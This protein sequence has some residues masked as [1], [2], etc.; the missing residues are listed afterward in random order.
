M[1]ARLE[2]YVV[3]SGESTP[4]P[5][6][7]PIVLGGAHDGRASQSGSPCWWR[8][9]AGCSCGR[10]PP[11][12]VALGRPSAGHARPRAGDRAD[13]VARRAPGGLCGRVD[14]CV[15][16]P[17]APAGGRRRARRGRPRVSGPSGSRSGRRTARGSCSTARAGIEIVSALGGPARLVVPD[18]R[19]PRL[20]PWVSGGSLM[21]AGWSPDGRPSRSCAGTPAGPRPGRRAPR[22]L[23]QDG[24]MHSFA[25]SPD[26]RWIACVRG[27]RQ[28]RQPS[29]MFGNIGPAR[30]WLVPVDGG[31]Q[32]MPVTDD[33]W[34]NASP[35]WA[36]RRPDAA[37]PTN[38]AGGAELLAAQA[39]RRTVARGDPVR[40]TNGLR[41]QAVSLSA[42]GHWLACADWTETS[43][44][45]S[46]PIPT[47]AAGIDPSGRAGDLR[48]PGHRVDRS[49][50][51]RRSAGVR[52]GSGGTRTCIGCRSREASPSG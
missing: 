19:D 1:A 39:R 46:L 42:N 32:A 3:S 35:T 22:P 33:Q 40:L 38:R 44:V 6:P 17:G 12:G 37:L 26:G 20:D 27:N 49:V 34:F 45:W 16:D 41:A 48:Q 14:E 43:N 4:A 24:E 2:S 25:W 23:T 52:L 51:G 30:I 15:G 50:G 28:S 7:A 31:G 47:A 10:G 21:P 9:L 5:R 29:F 18:E 11:R 8:R 36:P 13:D